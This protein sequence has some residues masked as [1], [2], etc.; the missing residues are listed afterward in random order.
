MQAK[1]TYKNNNYN[2]K[3]ESLREYEKKTNLLAE[4]GDR[5]VSLRR[6]LQSFG[7]TSACH[8]PNFRSQ[9]HSKHSLE[10][11]HGGWIGS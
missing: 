6:E 11:G 5:G 1:I 10:D 2:R 8:L 7:A 3:E 9:R 4:D